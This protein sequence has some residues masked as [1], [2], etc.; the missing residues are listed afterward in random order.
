MYKSDTGL[1][2]ILAKTTSTSTTVTSITIQKCILG[3]FTK[4]NL[5]LKKYYTHKINNENQLGTILLV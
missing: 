3:V 4:H 5:M 1:N 2:T